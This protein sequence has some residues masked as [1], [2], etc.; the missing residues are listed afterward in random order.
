M[1]VFSPQGHS[2]EQ[3][4]GTPARLQCLLESL[5]LLARQSRLE[6]RCPVSASASFAQKSIQV[7]RAAVSSFLG[8]PVNVR[9]E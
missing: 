1:S 7:P 8:F 2:I 3:L 5:L 4:P 9:E 6:V